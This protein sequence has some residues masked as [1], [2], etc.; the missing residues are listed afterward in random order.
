MVARAG[1]LVMTIDEGF[2]AQVGGKVPQF[3]CINSSKRQDLE[4][5]PLSAQSTGV[6]EE[7]SVFGV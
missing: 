5:E 2:P 3:Q 1:Y 7:D 4:D 6:Q